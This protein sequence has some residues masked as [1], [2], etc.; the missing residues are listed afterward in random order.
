V[1]RPE[2]PKWVSA[3]RQQLFPISADI[4][5]HGLFK[6]LTVRPLPTLYGASRHLIYRVNAKKG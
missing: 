3:V 1:A 6:A 5:Q 4:I 2:I